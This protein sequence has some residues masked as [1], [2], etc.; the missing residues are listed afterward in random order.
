MTCERFAEAGAKV[1][2]LDRQADEN[3]QL[4]LAYQER[5]LDISF[6]L[7]DVADPES[8][9]KFGGSLAKTLGYIDILVNNAGTLSFSPVMQTTLAEWERVQNVNCR[10][11]FLMMKAVGP[12]MG[13]KGVILNMSSSAAL[14]PTA[15]SAAYSVAK[16]GVVT[17][18]K[19]AALEMGPGVRVIAVCPGPLDT[20]MPHNYLK[21][22]PKEK[23]IMSQMI[24]RTI[25]KRLGQPSEIAD[26]LFFLAG[27][28][29]G[30]ITGT[31]ISADGGFI[32]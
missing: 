17:L 32:G 16:M 29:S 2:G 28:K 12:I 13:G 3:G 1:I 27:E 4:A 8:I 10:S 23:E 6:A 22:H 20:Q 25:V 24:D 31:V 9:E 11:A 14:A 7:L 19:I 18:S 26:L 15:F 30:F 5:G 21:G